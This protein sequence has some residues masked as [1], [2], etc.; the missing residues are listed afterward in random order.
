MSKQTQLAVEALH[1]ICMTVKSSLK[2][3]LKQCALIL[4]L[5]M[6]ATC[7]IFV[8]VFTLASYLTEE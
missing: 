4:A 7:N 3:Y 2:P 8:W 5:I 1:V 6:Y